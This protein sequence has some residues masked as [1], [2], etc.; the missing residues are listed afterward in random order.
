MEFRESKAAKHADYVFDS[1]LNA[2]ALYDEGAYGD[3]IALLYNLIENYNMGPL[4]RMKTLVMLCVLHGDWEYA[5][6]CRLE[7]EDIWH[8]CDK[9]PEEGYDKAAL[10]KFRASLDNLEKDMRVNPVKPVSEMTDEEV[11]YRLRLIGDV[12]VKAPPGPQSHMTFEEIEEMHH[13]AQRGA[14]ED[15][16]TKH[17]APQ[18]AQGEAVHIPTKPPTEGE[19]SDIQA[20]ESSTSGKHT[21]HAQHSRNASAPSRLTHQKSSTSERKKVMPVR[22]RPDA[23]NIVDRISA[24]D[25]SNPKDSLEKAYEMVKKCYH[26]QN[27]LECLAG[28]KKLLITYQISPK[29]RLKIFIYMASSA[30]EATE[31]E[32]YRKLAEGLYEVLVNELPAGEDPNTASLRDNLKRTASKPEKKKPGLF[33]SILRIGKKTE[34]SSDSGSPANSNTE[35]SPSPKGIRSTKLR[36]ANYGFTGGTEENIEALRR[37]AKSLTIHDEESQVSLAPSVKSSRPTASK[38][39]TKIPRSPSG[40]TIHHTEDLKRRN[41]KG[42][43]KRAISTS[44]RKSGRGVE[45]YQ[46]AGTLRRADSVKSV[47]RRS[48]PEDAKGKRVGWS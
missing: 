24:L 14:L 23:S 39:T 46:D 47:R 48:K 11:D 3:C 37:S 33:K 20:P 5:E 44:S 15:Y 29:R 4:P 10:A 16:Y 27:Y 19:P 28:A 34:D 32:E 36:K 26:D 42:G 18:S 30:R 8:H 7:A 9:H 12:L 25:P 1:L 45:T 21:K 13:I 43:H 31:R 38:S 6:A 40:N 2:E 35:L 22:L 17:R 41:S